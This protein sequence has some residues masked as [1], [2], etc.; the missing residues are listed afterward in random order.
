MASSRWK[1]F[2]F[3][4]RQTLTVP[5]DVLEDLI[6][7][8]DSSSKA[9]MRTLHLAA[10]SQESV[11]LTVS[12]AA[13]PLDTKP[14]LTT[15]LHNSSSSSNKATT[16]ND[17]SKPGSGSM[18][19]SV[20]LMWSSLTACT[21]PELSSTMSSEQQQQQQ[22]GNSSSSTKKSATAASASSS[23]KLPS[24]GQ[25][26]LPSSSSSSSTTTVLDGLVLA[27]ASSKD[28]TRV[29]CFDLTVRCNPPSQQQH[30]GS[31]T[32]MEDMD[33]WRGYWNPFVSSAARE[34]GGGGTLSTPATALSASAAAPQPSS[35]T[36]VVH[37]AA[38]RIP[39]QGRRRHQH[40]ALHVAC[41]GPSTATH[42]QIAVW[43]DPHL[44]LSCRKPLAT[45]S[46]TTTTTKK[47][48]CVVYTTTLSSSSTAAAGTSQSQTSWNA[49]NDGNA[50]VVSIVP[51]LVAVGTDAGVVL[52]YAYISSSNNNNNKSGASKKRTLLRSYVR[53]PPPPVPGVRVVS[54]QLAIVPLDHKAHV[55]VAYNREQPQQQP[56]VQ[57]Q[58]QST[59]TS[60][61]NGNAAN[62]TT[63]AAASTNNSSMNTAGI[64]CYDVPLP[65][66]A[67]PL[68]ALSAPSARH[69]L[70]GRYVGSSS[71]VDSSSSLSTQ[72]GSKEQ[73]Q[74]A[75]VLK[76]TVVRVATNTVCDCVEI[77]L[78]NL[79]CIRYIN[80]FFLAT[81]PTRRPLF[82]FSNRA[83]RRGTHRRHQTC[84][85]P[86][87]TTGS[88]RES[89]RSGSGSSGIGIR[90]RGFHRF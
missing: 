81:G 21:S 40:S 39:A 30:Q 22:G 85:L 52:V 8:I 19:D 65:N 58:Q 7:A 73:Q 59:T 54:V 64:C 35:T 20:S 4:E 68:T 78:L 13:L 71:L 42:H 69:D 28:S 86:H 37:T 24:Q 26:A 31:Q 57:Q 79:T 66:M 72:Y 41:L 23:V 63:T 55:F 14:A 48:D 44:H 25:A 89:P 49:S 82:L 62:A 61:S 84:H 33:G 60:S 53:I 32:S 18:E 77:V 38:C 76:V 2:A 70:D 47:D 5:P 17:E 67:S 36:G 88:C 6:P 50:A 43:E 74:A 3:F 11:S 15:L 9:S 56:A 75:A 80:L 16:K 10:S 46:T 83:N 27:F 12:T 45:A 51:G 87:P 29:H 34:G 90:P 1:R